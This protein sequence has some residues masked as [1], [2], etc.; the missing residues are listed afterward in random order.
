MW[1]ICAFTT[2]K[3]A[4]RAWDSLQHLTAFSLFTESYLIWLKESVWLMKWRKNIDLWHQGFLYISGY[5]LAACDKILVRNINGNRRVSIHLNRIRNLKITAIKFKKLFIFV[6]I[7][8]FVYNTLW[9][10][11]CASLGYSKAVVRFDF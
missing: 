4:T 11:F 5:L 6:L 10:N 7:L 2:K 1:I 8:W 3:A 9:K